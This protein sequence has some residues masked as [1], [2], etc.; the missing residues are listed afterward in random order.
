[1][2][3]CVDRSVCL[4]AFSIA[5]LLICLSQCGAQDAA[6]EPTDAALRQKWH[7]TYKAIAGSI[8]MQHGNLTLKLVDE[9][10]RFYTNPVRSNDQHGAIFLWTEEGRPAVIGS[11][12][13]AMNRQNQ[14]IRF[15]THEW[16]SLLSDVD[17]SATR[18]GQP[19]WTSGEAGIT[20][21]QL[22]VAPV[23]A[24]SRP[25]RLIQMRSIARRYA[26]TIQTQEESELRLVEQPLFRYA[27]GTAGAVDGAI[28]D[29]A[30]SNDPELLLLLEARDMDGKRAW[31]I[32]FARLGNKGMTV[33]EGDRIV[34]SCEQGSPGFSD[35]RYY[36]RWRAEEMP[37]VPGP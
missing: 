32:A 36:L 7:A 31:H 17:V 35:G 10:L 24:Q 28:F 29:F 3:V 4:S 13:S 21:S 15:V 6:D 12:W 26:P 22:D 33:K 2:S 1:M 5:T 23:P 16:H 8:A 25:A 20:W 14:A 19:L 11:I 30:M 34:W 18:E 37:A 27:E 9:P